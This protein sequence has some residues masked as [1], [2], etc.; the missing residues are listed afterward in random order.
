MVL[1]YPCLKTSHS[2]LCV[3]SILD[4]FFFFSSRR[5]H[6]ICGRDWS[7]DVCSSDLCRRRSPVRFDSGSGPCRVPTGVQF[8]CFEVV[9]RYGPP[10]GRFFLGERRFHKTQR[11]ERRNPAATGSN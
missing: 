2:I 6:T 7:S 10:L 1:A 5:R 4:S 3:S 8:C 9:P 11:L